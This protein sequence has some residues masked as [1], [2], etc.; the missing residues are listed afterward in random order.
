MLCKWR[1][2]AIRIRHMCLHKS[3]G[4]L[5][6]L[7]T[8]IVCRCG[9]FLAVMACQLVSLE[10]LPEREAKRLAYAKLVNLGVDKRSAE[11]TVHSK[12]VTAAGSESCL[13]FCR[14]E[15]GA[16]RLKIIFFWTVLWTKDLLAVYQT[17]PE[18][19]SEV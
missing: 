1:W 9:G 5:D 12:S 10:K 4:K 15:S 2:L 13:S 7:T 18:K 6:S 17:H 14:M 19:F 8:R 3:I 11:N 16:T